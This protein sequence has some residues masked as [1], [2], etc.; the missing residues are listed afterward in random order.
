[1]WQDRPTSC[2]CTASDLWRI[3]ASAGRPHQSQVDVEGSTR[4][5]PVLSC[6]MRGYPRA[7]T[8]AG[9]VT[10]LIAHPM[11]APRSQKRAPA[12]AGKTTAARR[13]TSRA[14]T[15][16]TSSAR[17]TRSSRS[18]APRT[19]PERAR[20]GAARSAR[21]RRSSGQVRLT[22]LILIATLVAAAWMVYPVFRLQYEHHRELDSL[23]SERRG[24][25]VAQRGAA[26]RGGPAQD[27][28]GRGGGR[29]RHAGAS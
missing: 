10:P 26:P 22:T 20:A 29:P 13:S 16:R 9:L 3:R 18:T 12:N 28:R 24:S 25:E 6:A 14:S 15:S 21:T 7:W 23:E 17:P 2:R 5:A 4:R 19:P 1:M 11:A 27:A 8:V